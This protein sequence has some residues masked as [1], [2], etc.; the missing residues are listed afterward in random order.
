M[1]D[2]NKS[3]KRVGYAL[4]PDRCGYTVQVLDGNNQP[5]REY[6]AGNHPLTSG[7][8]LSADNPRALTESRL[9][10]FAEQTAREL[11]TEYGAPAAAV[12]HDTDME[13]EES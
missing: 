12:F 11:A 10:R 3:A 5:I 7:D 9:L 8:Y 1:P 6:E 13:S 2:A 4:R